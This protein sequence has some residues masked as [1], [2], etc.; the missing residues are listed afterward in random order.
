MQSVWGRRSEKWLQQEA[1]HLGMN[2]DAG[3]R[4]WQVSW[5]IV[6]EALGKEKGQR[7]WLER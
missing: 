7:M 5:Q 6:R 2:K 4:K 1:N 3:V